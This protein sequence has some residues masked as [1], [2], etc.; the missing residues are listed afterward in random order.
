[1]NYATNR[2]N[3]DTYRKKLYTSLYAEKT[4][5]INILNYEK[6]YSNIP[7]WFNNNSLGRLSVV[8]QE[9]CVQY[10]QIH[11][12]NCI[13]FRSIICYNFSILSIWETS[14]IHIS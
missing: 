4:R 10:N 9:H 8:Y 14:S 7:L 2:V 3:S 5:S 12:R 13:N 6:K 11:V 1:M